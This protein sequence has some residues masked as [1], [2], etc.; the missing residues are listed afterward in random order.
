MSGIE[1][2]ITVAANI[3]L[4]AALAL[5]SHGS[6]PQQKAFEI[7]GH[8]APFSYYEVQNYLGTNPIDSAA[9]A[10][11]PSSQDCA[12]AYNKCNGNAQKP[13]A[14]QVIGCFAGYDYDASG[15]PMIKLTG[16]KEDL[17]ISAQGPLQAGSVGYFPETL[18]TTAP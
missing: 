5:S 7:N 18:P 10:S 15:L 12:D 14:S 16:F 8:G 13:P 2:G 1:K 4:D 6:A 17:L 11:G 3:V 9:C